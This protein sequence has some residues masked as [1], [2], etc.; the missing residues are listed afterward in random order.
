MPE[1][2]FLT[3][4]VQSLNNKYAQVMEH[5]LDYQ[6]DIVFLTETW[7]KINEQF[8]YS[9]THRLWVHTTSFYKKT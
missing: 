2:N 3:W 1:L 6:A 8:D 5:V 4:N 9:C 7:Q